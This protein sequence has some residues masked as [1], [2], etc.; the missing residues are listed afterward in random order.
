MSQSQ[1]N[2]EEGYRP[3]PVSSFEEGYNNQPSYKFPIQQSEQPAQQAQPQPPQY[4]VNVPPIQVHVHIGPQDLQAGQ[5]GKQMPKT[6][7][8]GPSLALAMFS[9]IIIFISFIIAVATNSSYYDNRIVFVFAFF[10][11]PVLL[12]F[13]WL[14]NNRKQ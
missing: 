9:I 12:A 2:Y 8:A 14:F 11:I 5:D 6:R 4:V 13:N 10:L 3:Q 1:V 7:S